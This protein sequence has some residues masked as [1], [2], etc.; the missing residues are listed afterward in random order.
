MTRNEKSVWKPTDDRLI[1]RTIARSQHPIPKVIQGRDCFASQ[2]FSKSINLNRN[3]RRE[4]GSPVKSIQFAWETD[5]SSMLFVS[6]HERI[7]KSTVTLHEKTSLILVRVSEEA[8]HACYRQWWK[9]LFVS[10]RSRHETK[11]NRKNIELPMFCLIKGMFVGD[12]LK[13]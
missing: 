10:K 4:S 5:V 3:P 6:S 12:F 8:R 13:T 7:E 1:L 2:V 9:M 11:K